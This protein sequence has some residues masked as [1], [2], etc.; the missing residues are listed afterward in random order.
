M[1]AFNIKGGFMYS[2]FPGP[3]YGYRELVYRKII[4]GRA[5]SAMPVS[6]ERL[7]RIIGRVLG[8]NN[9]FVPE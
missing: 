9:E 6:G 7:L 3:R 8:Y 4:R 5:Y 2:L 1:K